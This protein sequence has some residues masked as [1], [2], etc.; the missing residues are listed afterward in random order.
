VLPVKRIDRSLVM[1]HQHTA[2]AL[3]A[4]LEVGKRPAGPD[5][6]LHHAPEPFDRMQMVSTAR[7]QKRQLKRLV[8]VRKSRRERFRPMDAT[9]IDHHDDRLSGGAKEGHDLVDVLAKSLGRKMGDDFIEDCR[10]PILDGTKDAQQHTARHAAP[11]PIAHPGWAFE[12]LVAFDLTPAERADGQAIPLGF[13]PP[14]GA[15]QG[16]APQ[17]R[18]IGIKQKNLATTG[19]VCERREVNRRGG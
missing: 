17:D 19:A 4:L 6:V 16:K 8:P 14:A 9:A 12:G 15:G 1:S 13:T 5:P 3:R 10:R 2:P 18:F 11:T 7:W